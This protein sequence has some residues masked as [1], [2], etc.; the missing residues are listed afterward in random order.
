MH[1]TTLI[2]NQLIKSEGVLINGMMKAPPLIHGL[3]LLPR[4]TRVVSPPR[5]VDL[6]ERS[7]VLLPKIIKSVHLLDK[8]VVSAQD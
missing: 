6:R 7:I 2:V 1:W 4:K 3:V 8:S 5:I